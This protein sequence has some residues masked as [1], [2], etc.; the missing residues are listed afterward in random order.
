MSKLLFC[1]ACQALKKVTSEEPTC[2]CG[3][4][5]EEVTVREE[6]EL[7]FECPD[8]GAPTDELDVLCDGCAQIIEDHIEEPCEEEPAEKPQPLSERLGKVH[9]LVWWLG[10]PLTLGALGLVIGLATD[11]PRLGIGGAAL[12]F[13]MA[14]FDVPKYLEHLALFTESKAGMIGALW[15][16][17]SA[18]LVSDADSW[19]KAATIGAVSAFFWAGIF[20]ALS[21]AWH[22]EFYVGPAVGAMAGLVLCYFADVNLDARVLIEHL[23]R[24]G[25]LAAIGVIPHTFFASED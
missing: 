16:F 3:Q 5:L 9:S 11:N 22:A 7:K 4:P 12:G 21:I 24:I 1:K 15:G 6:V 17:V 8:C 14:F 23:F 2:D 10:L 25:L 20:W 13:I 19:A 18:T